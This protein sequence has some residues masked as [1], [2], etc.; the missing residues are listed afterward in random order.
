MC[1]V[2]CRVSRVSSNE[3]APRDVRRVA[4]FLVEA[5][6]VSSLLVPPF[7][8]KLIESF[9]GGVGGIGGADRGKRVEEGM[10][11]LIRR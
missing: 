6:Q 7:L 4:K 1:V 10:M 5:R 9:L 8:A 3:R 11:C 2:V